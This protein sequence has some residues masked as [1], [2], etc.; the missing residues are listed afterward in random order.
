MKP[1]RENVLVAGLRIGDR[2]GFDRHEEG[3]IDTRR[4]HDV[5]SR[6]GHLSRPRVGQ[7]RARAVDI[8]IDTGLVFDDLL[9]AAFG[10]G[11]P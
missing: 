11:L 1:L 3:A 6:N 2:C 9:N 10:R 7:A 4:R 8:D 5:P